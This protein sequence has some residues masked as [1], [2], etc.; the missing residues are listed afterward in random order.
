[1]PDNYSMDIEFYD[2]EDTAGSDHPFE[3]HEFSHPVPVPNV[4]EEVVVGGRGEDFSM[5]RGT[6]KRRKF[7][8]YSVDSKLRVM[9][10]L[11]GVENA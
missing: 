9:L 8:Y 2:D 11:T 7:M 1:M 4:S 3:F 10:Y 6:I 5:V